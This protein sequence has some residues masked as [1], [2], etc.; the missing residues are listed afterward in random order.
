MRAVHSK[1]AND[2]FVDFYLTNWSVSFAYLQLLNILFAKQAVNKQNNQPIKNQF[3]AVP[4]HEFN[5]DRYYIDGITANN[6]GARVNWTYVASQGVKLYSDIKN[7]PM[8][9]RRP[10]NGNDSKLVNSDTIDYH[11]SW[12]EEKPK[13]NFYFSHWQYDYWVQQNQWVT[14]IA[15]I[16]RANKIFLILMGMQNYVIVIIVIKMQLLI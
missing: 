14:I 12:L 10:Y 2:G 13:A 3:L 5:H 8:Y 9:K 6:T 15:V 16:N 7:T 1:T 11:L 4:D